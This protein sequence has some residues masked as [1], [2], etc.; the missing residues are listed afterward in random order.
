MSYQRVTLA[1]LRTQLV[2]QLKTVGTFWQLAE[3][4]AALN[5]ALAIWHAMTGASY[6]PGGFTVTVTDTETNLVDF[7][8]IT[9]T[10]NQKP[11][12]LTRVAIQ[13]ATGQYSPLQEISVEEM[14]QG[15]Y[16]WRTETASV[17][18]QRPEY[19]A[20]QGLHQFAFYPRTG[21]TCTFQLQ[22][23]TDPYYHYDDG[24]Y[25]NIGEGELARLIDLAQAILMFKEGIVEGTDNAK[26][27]RELFV[28]IAE[29]RNRD[30]MKLQTYRNYMGQDL[31][32]AEQDKG[33]VTQTTL[34][35]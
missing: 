6:S 32:Q 17:T 30:L 25:I 18:T 35:G 13:T 7:A 5:E 14:D 34:R 24:Y 15:F 2:D 23:Y 3:I 4:N 10:Y 12:V 27:L 28:Y 9:D 33:V 1:T 31:G 26:A 16:G 8:S 19:W 21:A 22:G 29:N 11:V 20:S